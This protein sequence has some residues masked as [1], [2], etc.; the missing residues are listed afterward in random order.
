MCLRMIYTHTH[1]Y[2][3]RYVIFL[4]D[5]VS[6]PARDSVKGVYVYMYV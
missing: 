1:T 6:Y 5:V 2:S 4:D 3:L